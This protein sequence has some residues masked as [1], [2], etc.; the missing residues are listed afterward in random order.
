MMTTAKAQYELCSFE[1][2]G[3]YIV[4]SNNNYYKVDKIS[5]QILDSLKENLSYKAIAEIVN[6]NN[7]TDQ[8]NE[9]MIKEICYEKS[10]NEIIKA[11][12]ETDN[13]KKTGVN[14][15]IYCRINLVEPAKAAALFQSITFL[16]SKM[17]YM[18]ILLLSLAVN[19]FYLFSSYFLNYSKPLITGDFL[20]LEAF[21]FL[22][23]IFFFHEIGHATA[24]MKHGIK[25]KGIGFGF[26]L[27]FPVLYTDITEIWLLD[28]KKRIQINLAGI[29][30]QLLINMFLITVNLLFF[31][32]AIVA[33]LISCNIFSMLLSFNP[34]F[35]YDG[36]WI[37]S[38]FFKIANLSKKSNE[39][40]RML[41]K[42]FIRPTQMM[43]VLK[44]QPRV[45]IIYSFLSFV[46]WTYF[47]CKLFLSLFIRAKF[48]FSETI[49]SGWT[50]FS[51]ANALGL[52]VT[53]ILLLYILLQKLKNN[54]HE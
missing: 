5:F 29:Y 48:L 50:F 30:F 53:C 32:N 1:N 7:S 13:D 34:F 35:K 37:V 20:R 10:M 28:R 51:Y 43:P 41:R 49:V 22:F 17:V 47:F 19:L 26:Y 21:V 25:A 18:P 46:F 9:A 6:E 39:C 3:R 45:L 42:L 44:N 23:I 11:I 38:D 33:T 31:K 4:I 27:V 24:A 8:Y 14:K 16:F 36:Y 15:S 2:E 54:Y 40:L 52:L 12:D